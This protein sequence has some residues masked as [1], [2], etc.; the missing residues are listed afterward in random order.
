MLHKRPSN[1]LKLLMSKQRRWCAGVPKDIHHWSFYTSMPSVCKVSS[2]RVE[3]SMSSQQAQGIE[4]STPLVICEERSMMT[5][6]HWP[7]MS[8]CPFLLSKRACRVLR[9]LTNYCSFCWV[10]NMEEACIHA[11]TVCEWDVTLIFCVWLSHCSSIWLHH[12]CKV[13]LYLFISSLVVSE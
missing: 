1:H 12:L 3:G 8:P 5:A 10:G 6:A 4:L 7:E 13:K 2:M 11:L 9:A